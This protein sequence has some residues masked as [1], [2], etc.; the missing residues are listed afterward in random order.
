MIEQSLNLLYQKTKVY[1]IKSWMEI[2][3]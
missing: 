2:F 3:I 1:F